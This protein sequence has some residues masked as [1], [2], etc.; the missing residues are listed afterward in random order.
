MTI[1]LNYSHRFFDESD[2]QRLYFGFT[3][4]VSEEEFKQFNMSVTNKETGET[5][6]IS[7]SAYDVGGEYLHTVFGVKEN[8]T[9]LIEVELE[10]K[11][12]RKSAAYKTEQLFE[13]DLGVAELNITVIESEE[14]PRH[15]NLNAAGSS[16]GTY[17]WFEERKCSLTR[18]GSDEVFEVYFGDEIEQFYLQNAGVWQMDCIATTNTGLSVE[19]NQV[20]NVVNLAPT[21]EASY[22]EGSSNR[23]FVFTAI[24]N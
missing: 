14:S 11:D 9:Y 23:N 13:F 15:Y 24:T 5:T 7:Y 12:G 4:L 2:P 20:I 19:F 21:L 3:N 10:F 17:G 6:L 22:T 1:F 16:P 18:I 8:G